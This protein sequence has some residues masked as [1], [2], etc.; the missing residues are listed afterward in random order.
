MAIGFNL[1]G[2]PGQIRGTAEEAGAVPDLGQAMMQ[3]FRSNLENIQGAPRLLS[4]QLLANQLANKIKSVQAKYAEDLALANIQKALKPSASEA[5]IPY[6]MALLQKKL[7][8]PQKAPSPPRETEEQ[9]QEARYKV[10][11]T[12]GIESDI[13]K[14]NRQ[15][16]DLLRM[17]EIIENNKKSF[18]PAVG[19]IAPFRNADELGEFKNL[20]SQFVAGLESQ[21]SQRGSVQALKAAQKYKADFRDKPQ[22]ALGKVNS[23]I[24]EI[25]QGI[26]Q[27]QENYTRLTGRPLK[28][29]DLDISEQMAPQQNI[30]S[31]P[32]V[33]G[34]FVRI[35]GKLVQE[36]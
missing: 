15:K 25:E 28:I 18:G 36:G 3:G 34:K 21:L 10:K 8:E 2:I 4:Q 23:A 31:K 7:N 22:Q 5:L 12:H 29:S 24:K 20:Q 9:K 6:R 32:Q 27:H 16:S 33:H 19:L 13:D 1:P 35:N 11:T 14:L 26:K 30:E 17:K